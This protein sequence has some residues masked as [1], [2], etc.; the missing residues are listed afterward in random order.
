MK[1]KYNSFS[2]LIVK[3]PHSFKIDFKTKSKS[4]L[5]FTPHGGGI[6]PGTT[7]LCEWFHENS[8][9]YYSFTGTGKNCKDLHITST[10]FDEGQLLKIIKKHRY[11]ISFHGMT[12]YM[13]TKYK[14]DIFLGGLN[15][16]LLNCTEIK[17]R[18]NGYSVVT[19]KQYPKSILAASSINN[20]TNKCNSG[21]GLQIELSEFI[22]RKFFK[23]NLRIKKGRLHRTPKF[24]K[25]CSIIKE[26]VD[27]YSKNGL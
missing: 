19:S 10:R 5:I 8:F 26:V 11:A 4:F 17:L 21:V 3:R 13:K 22:R 14:A 2:D 1:D 18:A 12:D 20:I 6:E 16:I 24:D 25:F 9:S 7:E 15:K 27:N 23:G